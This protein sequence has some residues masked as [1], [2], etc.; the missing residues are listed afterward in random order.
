MERL[1]LAG[2]RQRIDY[3][4]RPEAGAPSGRVSGTGALFRLPWVGARALP[5]A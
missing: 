5:V 3:Q 1:R 2:T 4:G